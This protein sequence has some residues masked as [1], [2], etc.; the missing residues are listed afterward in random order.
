MSPITAVACDVTDHGESSSIG[1]WVKKNTSHHSAGSAI[2]SS[3]K[4]HFQRFYEEGRTEE[5]NH[6]GW[7]LS[8]DMENCFMQR[9]Y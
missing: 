7:N 9:I 2:Q 5:E 8:L 4:D 6:H 3:L 1:D